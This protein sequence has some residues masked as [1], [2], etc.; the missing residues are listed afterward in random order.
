MSSVH[1]KTHY[2]NLSKYKKAVTVLGW[3][4]LVVIN[5]WILQCHAWLS[6]NL[7]LKQVIEFCGKLSGTIVILLILIKKINKLC[8]ESRNSQTRKFHVEKLLLSW[9]LSFIIMLLET[10]YWKWTNSKLSAANWFELSH[11]Y[12]C[13]CCLA[14]V[15]LKLLTAWF[16]AAK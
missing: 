2:I 13:V 1:L 7:C 11:Q 16:F 10:I 4:H 3:L 6:H 9:K 14:D 8:F 12:G 5:D 15:L